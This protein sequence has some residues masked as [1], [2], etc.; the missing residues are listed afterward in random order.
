M[1][2]VLSVLLAA[3]MVMG[4]SVASMAKDADKVWAAQTVAGTEAD[5]HACT[6]MF[7]EKMWVEHNE[8][9]MSHGD[10]AT[11]WV[12]E[13]TSW[14]GMKP[15][16]DLYF[17]IDNAQ[18]AYTGEVDHDWSI[19]IKGNEHIVNASFVAWKN[20]AWT[21]KAADLAEE[22]TEKYVKV[23]IVDELDD[24]D[25]QEA[26]FYMYI[27]DED[28][29]CECAECKKGHVARNCYSKDAYLCYNFDNETVKIVDFDRTND[30]DL[31]AKWVVENKKKGEA[32]FDFD[33]KAYFTTI[34]YPEEEV[35]LNFVYS[36]YV[37]ELEKIFDYEAEYSIYN[38]K[39]ESDEFGKVGELFIPADTDKT[40]I[41][42][43]DGE[44]LS[45]V[46]ATAVEE[47]KVGHTSKSLE[48]FV[49][50]TNELG[51]YV[52]VDMEAPELA[53]E[54]VEAEVEADKA[55]P[56]TGAA[57]FVGA[58]VAMA[59]VSVAAAGALALKK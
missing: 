8:N 19:N 51:Q 42:A 20:G 44:E 29:D 9:N 55:N 58:A 7:Y 1:K 12:K 10:K 28:N 26:E 33:S 17:R 59:V 57:D 53:E 18:G 27:A 25:A 52:V 4:M 56:E 2:K 3:A 37:K 24:L 32:V 13:L 47:Y 11:E 14:D 41:Y 54:E 43:W 34:M 31:V 6:L 48:G 23:E 38:F 49:I 50:E 35:I 21:S 16:D 40:F 5:V 15:G 39:G 46:E 45:E 36:E 22:G 30:A